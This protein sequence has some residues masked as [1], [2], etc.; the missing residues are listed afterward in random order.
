VAYDVLLVNSIMDGMNLVSK[1]G[2][3]L[4]ESDG[5]LILSAGAGSFGELGADAVVIDDPLDIEETATR[6]AEALALRP[7]ERAAK[8]ERLRSSVRARVP[9]DWLNDQIDDLSAIRATGAP[10]SGLQQLPQ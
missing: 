1:E 2:P 5:V 3:T 10:R 4:N 7:D 9:E 8:A 6:I